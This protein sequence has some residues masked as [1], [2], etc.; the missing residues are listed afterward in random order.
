MRRFPLKKQRIFIFMPTVP[1]M[2]L[3]TKS[4]QHHLVTPP[5][6]L[7]AKVT[8]QNDA[9]SSSAPVPYT[10]YLMHFYVRVHLLVFRVSTNRC[11][12]LINNMH[13]EVKGFPFGGGHCLDAG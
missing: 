8:R 4:P 2:L 1:E 10:W 5:E 6:T 7:E 13:F 12:G 3:L 11:C 9:M